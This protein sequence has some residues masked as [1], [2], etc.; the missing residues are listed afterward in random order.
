VDAFSGEVHYG[1][2]PGSTFYRAAMLVGGMAL[3]ALVAVDGSSLAV[4]LGINSDSDDAGGLIIGGLFVLVI[5]FGIMAAAYRAFR[6]GEHYEF[7]RGGKFGATGLRKL[8][9]FDASTESVMKWV[10]R[11]N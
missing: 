10:S 4:Y 8:V 1:K 11:S 2:A 7:R 5:G 6:Y 9:D 3:G